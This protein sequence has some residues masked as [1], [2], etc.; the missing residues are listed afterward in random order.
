[1]G[2]SRKNDPP[3]LQTPTETHQLRFTNQN[4]LSGWLRSGDRLGFISYTKMAQ[5]AEQERQ[6]AD[7]AETRASQLADRLRAAGIDPDNLT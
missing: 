4:D 3:Y 7:R 6:R 5:R 1:M 2:L